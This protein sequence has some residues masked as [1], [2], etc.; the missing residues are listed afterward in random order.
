MIIIAF[1]VITKQFI[2]AIVDDMIPNLYIL[3]IM[4]VITHRILH[5]IIHIIMDKWIRME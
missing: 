3:I 4:L 2:V 1:I 5:V